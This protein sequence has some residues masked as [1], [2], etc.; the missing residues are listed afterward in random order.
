M[1]NPF[2]VREKCGLNQFPQFTSFSGKKALSKYVHMF[3]EVN[4]GCL[5]YEFSSWLLCNTKKISVKF[6]P[7]R[8]FIHTIRSEGLQTLRPWSL[9]GQVIL[10]AEL[11]LMMLDSKAIV[12]CD[13]VLTS[14]GYTKPDRS[15]I[16]ILRSNKCSKSDA[17]NK[18]GHSL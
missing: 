5:F 6:F 12:S 9:R 18:S 13:P 8:E 7:D 1:G 3:S 15:Q 10:S 16:S 11:T 4:T 17:F 2:P 14:D